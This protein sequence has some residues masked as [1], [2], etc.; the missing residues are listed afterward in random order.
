VLYAFAAVAL[1]GG[2]EKDLPTVSEGWEA[3][4]RFQ[5]FVIRI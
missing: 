5:S 4:S 3:G 2:L 1:A